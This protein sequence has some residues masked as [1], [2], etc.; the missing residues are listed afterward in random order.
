MAGELV[1]LIMFK[2]F[3]TLSGEADFSTA[4][5]EVSQYTQ[6]ILGAW[7]GKLLGTATPTFGFTVEE[8]TDQLSWTECSGTNTSEDPGEETEMQIVATLSKRWFRLTASLTG[9]DPSVTC[10]ALGFF[11]KRES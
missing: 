6:A 9:T 7:R 11:E 3:T 10:W 4:G 5:M 1:P 8:S 2:K